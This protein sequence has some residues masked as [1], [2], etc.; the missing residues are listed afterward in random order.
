MIDFM[1]EVNKGLPYFARQLKDLPY[2]YGGHFGGP[3]L[4]Q[5]STHTGQT[6]I[7]F[8]RQLGIPLIP[9]RPHRIDDGIEAVR[10][11]L[12][13][14]WFD[15][16]RCRTGVEALCQYHRRKDEAASTLDKPVYRREP[17]H[18][19]WASHPADAFR[20]IAMAYREGRIRS[21]TDYEKEDDMALAQSYAM[22]TAA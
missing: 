16:K 18:N 22:E 11:I 21:N 15:A 7:D 17:N 10:S 5:A 1:T 8:S 9:V 20:H 4:N 6:T 12:N 2:V 19:H 13:Q 14:C 3:D